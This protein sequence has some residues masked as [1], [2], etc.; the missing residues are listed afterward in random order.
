MLHGSGANGDAIRRQS[1]MDSL[2]ESERF[3]VAYPDG[4]SEIFGLN[5]DWN[6]GECCGG[7]Y[8]EHVDDVTFLKAIIADVSAQL[9]V[10]RR[11]IYVAGFSD[12][13]RMTYRAGCEMADEL[14]AIAAVAGSLVDAHCAPTRPLPVIAFHG[15][16]DDEVPFDDSAYTRAPRAV[17]PSVGSLPSSIKFWMSTDGCRD[18]SDV[19]AGP[20]VIEHAGVGCAAD[21]VFYAIEGAGHKW[22]TLRLNGAT[23]ALSASQIIARFFLRHAR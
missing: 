17:S 13:A 21:V 7:A 16:G 19:H 8:V 10:D 23:T 1:G 22:P 3:L 5:A 4:S 18:A 20:M 6:A 15:T 12:G 11:R 2:S 9:P 14:A